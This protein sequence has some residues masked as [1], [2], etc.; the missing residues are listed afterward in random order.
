MRRAGLIGSGR[1]R[2]AGGV[3]LGRVMTR[4]RPA[5]RRPPTP[6]RRPTQPAP[7]A[8]ASR[9]V[10]LK[11]IGQLRLAAL[12][13]LAARRPRGACS[14]SSRP[15]ASGVLV[16]RQAAR[17]RSSTSARRSRAGGEQGLLSMAFAPDYAT[18]G[19]LLRLLHRQARRPARRRVQARER[20]PRRPGLGARSCCAWT[21]ARGQPQRRPAA[22]RPRQACSTS[23]PA[24]AA[25]AATSTARAA[26]RRTSARCSARS[27][28]ST[29]A[30]SGG[31][32]YTVPA[33]NPFV[34]R[35]R[36]ARRDLRLRPA[37]PVALLVRPPTG[38][39]AIGDVGQDEVEE[40]DF[41][42]RGKGRGRQLRLARRSRAARATR[43]ARARPAHVPPVITRTPRRRLVLDHRRR[44]GPRPARSP[45]CAGA[46]CSATSASR[47]ILSARLAPAARASVRA[48]PLQGREP[49]LVRRGRAR[50]RLRRLA[51]RPGLPARPAMSV[52]ELAGSTSRA[53]A[54]RT[55][56]RYTLVGHEHLGRRPRPGVGD[57]S[58]ARRSTSTST[59][60]PPRSRRAAA[61]A[62]SRSRTTTAT[63]SRALLAL[64]ER[65]G[66][67]PVGARRNAPTCG[68]R[69]RPLR[70]AR[71][72]SRARATPPTTSSSSPD[73]AA[74]TGDA[75]LGE[76][77]VFVAG[78]PRRVP[79]RRCG[80]CASCRCA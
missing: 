79:R 70:P 36:R 29:R 28:A 49:V 34:G 16:G 50:P 41:V 35:A 42:R 39:L 73:G 48:T 80:A 52:D 33:D 1:W 77:S 47:G 56:A 65:L 13:H 3:R 21:P 2:A 26:T 38:D 43:R 55:P 17:S 40:I 60:W 76:G 23:A 24:T 67:P 64:R 62:G 4:A 12:R 59:R 7:T 75:V 18:S 71:G 20:R 32:P 5:P 31:R 19:L 9:G 74:F 58:R 10:R 44:R 37:Q 51:Q 53:C 57:R 8:T 15:A 14:S 6:R 69:R 27:C 22:V 54:P 61:P 68:W 45:A 11:S 66:R 46:T 72:R 25:A 30:Q 78:R 63:T